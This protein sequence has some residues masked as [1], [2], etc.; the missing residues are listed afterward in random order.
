MR[1]SAEREGFEPSARVQP[2]RRF[3]K[4]VHSASLSPFQRCQ[5]HTGLVGRQ[6]YTKHEPHWNGISDSINWTVSQCKQHFP[7]RLFT[8][9]VEQGAALLQ[10]RVS[11]APSRIRTCDPRF[12]KPLHRPL[13]YGGETC[14][15]TRTRSIA[16]ERQQP[17]CTT[18]QSP[19]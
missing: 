10:A 18:R 8:P 2:V 11:S 7:P 5:P 6:E 1:T 14:V 17:R 12:R 16:I 3:S 4:P 9:Y 19:S 15:T 13:C